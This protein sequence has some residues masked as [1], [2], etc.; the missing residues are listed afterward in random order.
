MLFPIVTYKT[1]R[2]G[3]HGVEHITITYHFTLANGSEK[4][5]LIELDPTTLEPVGGLPDRLPAWAELG[6]HQCPHCPLSADAHP[7]C[8]LAARIVDIECR[9]DDILSFEEVH[10]EVIT[11]ERIVSQDMPT[12][13]CLSSLMGLVMA[14]CGCPV[15]AF[16]KPM[17]RFHLPLAGKEETLYR[18]TSMYLLSRY[19]LKKKGRAAEL[20]LEGL[21]KIYHDLQI[22]NASV[23]SRLNAVTHTDSLANAIMILDVY[24]NTLPRAI[25]HSLEEIRHL[26]S[27]Y[28]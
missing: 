13:K 21:M 2:G 11:R 19:L 10:L 9:F 20:E 24:T 27:A 3:E 6:F 8:P 28:Y 17:A 5:F 22:L 7:H 16:L 1:F 14:T 18:A 4:V 15:T 12:Q 26:F 23:S 25:E